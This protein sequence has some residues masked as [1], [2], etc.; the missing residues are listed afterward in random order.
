[1][2]NPSLGY[3]VQIL[4]VE[5][6]DNQRLDCWPATLPLVNNVLQIQPQDVSSQQAHAATLHDTAF[7]LRAK[8][9]VEVPSQ[10]FPNVSAQPQTVSGRV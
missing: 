5:E 2:L 3:K 10:P 8:M 1:M 6:T 9:A 7:H 4:I